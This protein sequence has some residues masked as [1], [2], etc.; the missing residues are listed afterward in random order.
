MSRQESEESALWV[1]QGGEVLLRG[2]RCNECEGLF[3]PPQTYGCE[4]CGAPDTSLREDLFI[5]SGN[6]VSFTTVHLN[7]NATTPYQLCEVMSV[8]RQPI[9]ARLEHASPNIGDSVL[10]ALREYDDKLQF[11]FVPEIKP[12]SQ[13][14]RAGR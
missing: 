2:T 10:G 11:V 6:L 4:A 5:P 14:E 3:F 13:K 8:A 9:R 7:D 12:G 1:E